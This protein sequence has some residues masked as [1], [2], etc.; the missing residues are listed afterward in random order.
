MNDIHNANGALMQLITQPFGNPVR[1]NTLQNVTTSVSVFDITNNLDNYEL[2]RRSDQIEIDKLV[3]EFNQN[4]ENENENF[5]INEILNQIKTNLNENNKFVLFSGGNDIISIDLHF[6]VNLSEPTIVN[7]TLIIN[8]S[9]GNYIG[10][11]N[12]IGT[13][14]H[15]QHIRLELSNVLRN[16]LLSAKIFVKSIFHQRPERLRLVEQ[17]HETLVQQIGSDTYSNVS[18][19]FIHF[20]KR[21]DCN[22]FSKGFFISGNINRITRFALKINNQELIT[23]DHLLLQVYGKKFGQN[24]LYI[25][26]N[27]N[28]NSPF[29]DLTRDGLTGG[30]NFSRI[31][32]INLIIEWSEPQTSFKVYNITSNIL[33]IM[34]GMNG[35]AYDVGPTIDLNIYHNQNLI[36]NQHL[37]QD[38][39]KYQTE[40]KPINSEKNI[41]NISLD[42]INIGDNYMECVQCHNCFSDKALQQWLKIKNEC[43]LCKIRWTSKIVYVNRI[44][45]NKLEGTEVNVL[46]L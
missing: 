27:P 1:H 36:Q 17:E 29:T 14:W 33:R 38:Q 16:S 26:F 41:C 37:Y 39:N 12:L 3:L 28:F 5:N 25:P 43:P 2:Q 40:F 6:A 32:L 21:I 31:D 7:N 18:E 42:L 45:E 15:P 11:L 35:L 24:L 30:L 22:G 23:Y 13:Q 10:P 20:N 19:P 4:N 9:M 34:A 8:L 44:E 46:D